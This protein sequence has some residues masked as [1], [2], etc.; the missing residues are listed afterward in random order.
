MEKVPSEEEQ[1]RN[2]IYHQE[3]DSLKGL[4]EEKLS[5]LKNLRIESQS[6]META[7]QEAWELRCQIQGIFRNCLGKVPELGERKNSSEDLVIFAD[8]EKYSNYLDRFKNKLAGFFSGFKE[9][10]SKHPR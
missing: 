8:S 2:Q 5:T 6:D 4:I 10:R 3:L 1:D 7:E 9:L